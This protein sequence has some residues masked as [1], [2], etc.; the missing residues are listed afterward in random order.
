MHAFSGGGAVVQVMDVTTVTATKHLYV[1]PTAGAAAVD[2]TADLAVGSDV[3]VAGY[4]SG[5]VFNQIQHW[6]LPAGT[7]LGA[8]AGAAAMGASQVLGSTTGIAAFFYTSGDIDVWRFDGSSWTAG[9]QA[10]TSAAGLTAGADRTFL[11]GGAQSASAALRQ[12]VVAA[13]PA[14]SVSLQPT[15]RTSMTSCFRLSAADVALELTLFQAVFAGSPASSAVGTLRLEATSPANVNAQ[16]C[17]TAPPGSDGVVVASF[18]RQGWAASGRAWDEP[19]SH[20][21]ALCSGG[22]CSGWQDASFSGQMGDG[23]RL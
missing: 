17:L 7:V 2:I 1:S 12:V 5:A 20:S 16:V 18:W 21:Y 23:V 8:S 3:F 13:D 4:E 14:S 22:T 9:T 11:V 15:K 10:S 6:A 19:V